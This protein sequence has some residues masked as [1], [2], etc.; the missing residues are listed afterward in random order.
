LR[1]KNKLLVPNATVFVA[2]FCIMV[3]ELTAS[4]IVARHLGSSLYTWTSVIGVVLAGIAIGNYIGGLVA[5]RFQAAKSL[6]F[7]FIL[8]SISCAMVPV[9]NRLIGEFY[10]LWTLPWPVV[11]AM[12][13]AFTFFL[14]SLV[15]GMIAPVVAKFALNQ[16]L[17]TGRTIGNV[18]AWGAA[19]SIAGTFFTGFFLISVMGTSGVIWSVALVL[20]LMGILYAKKAC[21]P[22]LW[23]GLLAVLTVFALAP[24][25]RAQ[26]IGQKVAL[27]QPASSDAIYEDESQYSYIKVERSPYSPGVRWL[28]LDQ[29][30]H[31]VVRMDDSGQVEN[32]YP[33]EG[34]L[35]A[36]TYNLADGQKNLSTLFIGGGGYVVPRY[37][38]KNWPGSRI[39]VVEIDPAVTEAAMNAFGLSEDNPLKI[40]HRDARKH[41]NELFLRKQQGEQVPQ[42]DFIYGDAF[43]DLYVPSHLV[44][45]EF[46]EKIN[47]LL[48]PEGYYLVNISDSIESGRF[49]GAVLNTMQ[50][51]FPYVHVFLSGSY[52]G[53]G[54][55]RTFTILCSK[56]EID[57]G[58]FSYEGFP[59]RLVGSA[60][61][62]R[63]GECSRNIILTDNYAPVENLLQPVLRDRGRWIACTKL[64]ERGDVFAGEARLEKAKKYYRK[65]L[66]VYPDYA[67]AHN[68]L[69]NALVKSENVAEAL[70]HYQEALRI[71]PE[72]SEARSNIATVLAYQGKTDEALGYY[73]EVLELQPDSAETYYNIGTILADTGDLK[74]AIEHYQEALDIQPDFARAYAGLGAVAIQQG[75]IE[76]ALRYYRN[77][78]EILPENAKVHNNIGALLVEMGKLD[79]ALK[80]YREALRLDPEYAKARRNIEAILA[81]QNKP[82]HEIDRQGRE[83]DH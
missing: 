72:F 13:V 2:S 3:L 35:E 73:Q 76:A 38:E 61:L 4:R 46:N 63:L 17:A 50:K 18:Y 48:A 40:Y 25:P 21:I 19:G 34:L 42:F 15:L 33:C 55:R 51:T 24:Q 79:E 62:K 20:A 77:S 67:V 82:L 74:E 14:P 60:T 39:E 53:K 58:R 7:L 32:L 81:A 1:V 69:G 22:Y 71:A 30:L 8:A 54:A 57:L 23:A 29:L 27:R 43:S 9:S 75:K 6:S 65:A 44:T 45:Y 70:K 10:L 52:K 47:K 11:V 83:Y 78:L 80:H 41:I 31:S 26:A 12:H 64:V 49:I 36:I 68:N 37:I 16:G 59:G 5:D 28:I 66:E 56:E